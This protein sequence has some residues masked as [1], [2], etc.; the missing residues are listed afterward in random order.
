MGFF[1]RFSNESRELI[2]SNLQVYFNSLSNGSDHKKAIAEVI[3]TRY[4][5][6]KSHRAELTTR[7]EELKKKNPLWTCREETIAL[8]YL[9]WCM[10]K[11][12]LPGAGVNQNIVE[13]YNTFLSR[14]SD[15]TEYKPSDRRIRDL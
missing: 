2:G 3:R 6:I 5:S 11:K 14:Y 13:M 8:I 10:E 4:H 12:S 7:L 9:I 1:G 15:M